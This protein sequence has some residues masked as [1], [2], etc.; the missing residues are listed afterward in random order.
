MK[1]KNVILSHKVSVCWKIHFF[2]FQEAFVEY[3]K[4]EGSL[5][6][7]SSADCNA[8]KSE[9]QNMFFSPLC[10]DTSTLQCL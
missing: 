5:Y 8:D 7:I 1:I 3:L 9:W 6:E 4:F 10:S 2:S